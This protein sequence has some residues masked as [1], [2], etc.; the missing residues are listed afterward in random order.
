MTTSGSMHRP[1]PF[2]HRD[3]NTRTKRRLPVV[4]WLHTRLTTGCPSLCLTQ[5]F[6]LSHQDHGRRHQTLNRSCCVNC[7]VNRRERRALVCRTSLP[8][9]LGGVK[10]E[11]YKRADLLLCESCRVCFTDAKTLESDREVMVGVKLSSV[12]P[13]LNKSSKHGP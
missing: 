10:V 7:H 13:P 5:Q 1:T 11:A 9:D 12:H 2:D 6:T 4:S 8:G 3:Q